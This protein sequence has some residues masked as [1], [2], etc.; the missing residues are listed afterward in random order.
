MKTYKL[1]HIILILVFA[2]LSGEILAQRMQHAPAR[3][4][5]GGAR[6]SGSINGGASRTASRPQTS[7][8]SKPSYTPKTQNR[9][10]TTASRPQVSNRKTEI[11]NNRT[12]NENKI[13]GGGNKINIDN[14]KNVN[15]NVNRNVRVNNYHSNR[16]Y[17][18]H[19]GYYP[20][21]YHPYRPYYY[22]PVWHPFGFFVATMFTTA[23]IVSLNNQPYYYNQGVYYVEVNNGYNSVPPPVNITINNLPDG[24]ES[25]TLNDL[26]YYYYAGTFYEK[27]SD[28]FKVIVAPDGAMV[29]NIP[30]GGEEL[31]I[32]GN[33]YVFYNDTYFQPLAKDGKDL[34]QV[35]SMEEN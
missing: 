2:F 14:S 6:P 19:R 22:G 17:N 26:T 33:K 31:E 11:N 1:N 21:H 34:Y 8:A 24:V 20:Y 23:V 3:G 4:G 25:V 12:G 13:G 16:Y 30:D 10:N 27:V 28:G 32:D 35:V 9:A 7:Q 29:L 15:V 18:G 5:G